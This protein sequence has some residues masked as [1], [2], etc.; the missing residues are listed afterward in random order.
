[1]LKDAEN[2]SEISIR[3]SKRRN[4]PVAPVLQSEA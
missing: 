2:V 1:M 3:T 4:D